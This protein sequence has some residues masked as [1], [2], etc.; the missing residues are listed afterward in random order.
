MSRSLV[1][2]VP[3]R[4]DCLEF[5]CS[6]FIY[7]SCWSLLLLGSWG[8]FFFKQKTAYEMRISDWSS[9]VCSS[10]LLTLPEADAFEAIPGKGIAA[11]VAGHDVL[12][13]S[14][15]FL[16]ERGVALTMLDERTQ[17]LEAQGR[18]VITVARNGKLLGLLAFGDAPRPDAAETIRK[19]REAGVKTVLITGD[20]RRAAGRVARELGLDEVHAEV[21]PGRKAD[22]IRRLQRQG[23]TAMVGDGI[24]DAPALMQAEVAIAMGSGTDIAIDAADIII[25]NNRLANIVEEREISRYSYIKMVRSEEHTSE[26]QSLMRIKSTD[27]C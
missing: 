18:T 14:P 11:K 22:L 8:C 15:R 7:I 3:N 13:G 19:L 25:L 21:L 23:R 9:D 10:D 1:F 24:N 5:L 6:S 20:N 17:T 2:L 26:L 27:L 12:V 16:A 4:L